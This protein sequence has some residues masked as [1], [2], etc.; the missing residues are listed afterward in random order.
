MRARDDGAPVVLAVSSATGAGLEPLRQAIFDHAGPTRRSA[1]G[2]AGAA[3]S[4]SPSTL[5]TGR[6]SSSG[7]RSS[8]AA[9]TRSRSSGPAVERL[10]QRHDLENQEALAYIEERL[11]AMG[12]IKELEAQGFEP[13][14]EIAIGDVAFELYPGVTG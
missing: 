5:S 6:P 3:A 7:Y 8:A 1:G 9:S 13:G 2:R 10:S 4:R 12:V 14:E 11:R